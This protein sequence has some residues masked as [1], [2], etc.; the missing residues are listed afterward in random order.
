MM[1]QKPPS[2]RK[3]KTLYTNFIDR[4]FCTAISSCRICFSVRTVTYGYVISMVRPLRKILVGLPLGR[5]SGCLLF[6]CYIEGNHLQW[7]MIYLRWVLVYGNYSP[8]S[9]HLKD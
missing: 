2:C 6:V 9:S 7:R 1:S 5:Q 4:V 8:E 3:C